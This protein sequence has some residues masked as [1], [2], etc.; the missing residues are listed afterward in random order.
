MKAKRIWILTIFLLCGVSCGCYLPA[1]GYDVP[2]RTFTWTEGNLLTD[3][4]VSFAPLPPDWQYIGEF[5]VC[6]GRVEGGGKLFASSEEAVLVQEESPI[7]ASMNWRE[8]L[9]TDTALPE[10]GVDTCVAVVKTKE[11]SEE[12]PEEA[13]IEL[14]S[15]Y[16]ARAET[17]VLD[18]GNPLTVLDHDRAEVY[19]TFPSF[20]GLRLS[21]G[22]LYYHKGCMVLEC[23]RQPP[24]TERVYLKIERRSALYDQMLACI[25]E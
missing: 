7:G 4:T 21:V 5:P 24:S 19:F 10:V 12:L 22:S 16:A 23:L 11:G 2:D 14:C 18:I 17:G 6:I 25:G 1:I 15:L 9:R 3:G 20:E 13:T 8:Q